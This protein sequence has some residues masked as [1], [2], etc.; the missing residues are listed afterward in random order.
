MPSRLEE[1]VWSKFEV[2][3][4]T[5]ELKAKVLE[6]LVLGVVHPKRLGQIDI[7]GSL[8]D[9]EIKDDV[10]WTSSLNYS[11]VDFTLLAVGRESYEGDTFCF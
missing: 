4:V 5:T 9:L 2:D 1:L 6:P 10:P 8:F 7:G 3:E 11:V